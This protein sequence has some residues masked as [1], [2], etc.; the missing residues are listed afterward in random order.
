MKNPLTG[1]LSIAFI[2][3]LFFIIEG[4]AETSFVS[5]IK[6]GESWR[7]VMFS[8]IL[9]VLFGIIILFVF[10]EVTLWIIG[11]LVGIKLIFAGWYLISLLQRLKKRELEIKNIDLD[12]LSINI[13]VSHI[14][15]YL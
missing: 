7:F 9:T 12:D 14:I 4:I 5:E 11:L 3:R 15:Y 13:L 10:P 1:V 2:V 6:P 8:G